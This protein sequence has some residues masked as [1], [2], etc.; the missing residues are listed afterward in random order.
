MAMVKPNLLAN[1]N[2]GRSL[3]L[4]LN[5]SKHRTLYVED[6]ES[7]PAEQCLRVWYVYVQ[8]LSLNQYLLMNVFTIGYRS[9]SPAFY[10]HHSKTATEIVSE[11]FD[12][13]ESSQNNFSA[14]MRGSR[15]VLTGGLRER[16]PL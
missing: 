7:S 8:E 10:K 5:K 13:M 2:E 3:L 1:M 9:N 11:M 4:V 6:S 12:L 15:S 16:S 14:I